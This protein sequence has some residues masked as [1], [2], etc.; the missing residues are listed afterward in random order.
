MNKYNV[1]ENSYFFLKKDENCYL[2]TL[3]Q[4]L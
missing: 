4:Y 1:D 2:F 3:C